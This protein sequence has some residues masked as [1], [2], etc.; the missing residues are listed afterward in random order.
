ML[1]FRRN[2]FSAAAKMLI[3]NDSSPLRLSGSSS[4]ISN[5][6]DRDVDL[7]DPE[8]ESTGPSFQF[9]TETLLADAKDI[10]FRPLPGQWHSMERPVLDI[11]HG[12]TSSSIR[13]AAEKLRT[14]CH[15]IVFPTETVYGIGADARLSNSVQL[16]FAVKNRP[17]DNPLIV[18]IASIAMLRSLLDSDN[19][20]NKAKPFNSSLAAN[21]PS[22]TTK[23][24]S[25][26]TAKSISKEQSREECFRGIPEIYWP[27]IEKFWPGPLTILL[28]L[29]PVTTKISRFVTAGQKTFGVRMPSNLVALA[30]LHIANAPLAA[31][32][33]NTSSKPSPTTAQ[34]VLDDLKDRIPVI[35]DGGPC[36]VGLESTVVDGLCDPP[37]I[38][39][40]GGI[41][42]EQIQ[43]CGNGWERCVVYQPNKLTEES[44][45]GLSEA[46]ESRRSMTQSHQT[47]REQKWVPRAPGMKYRHYSPEADVVVTDG[48][49]T[50]AELV[51][52]L[53]QDDSA[54]GT[55]FRSAKRIGVLISKLWSRER[56]QRALSEDK[57]IIHEIEL[58]R[59]D[60]D[61]SRHIFGALRAMDAL[62]PDEDDNAHEENRETK[63]NS[64]PSK[65]TECNTSQKYSERDASPHR[66]AVDIILVEGVADKD[67]GLAIMNRL[68]KAAVKYVD[69]SLLMQLK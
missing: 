60:E 25:E 65:P 55:S 10:K 45:S 46:E 42:L 13:K 47:Q 66:A 21:D 19:G 30:L 3:H 54:G 32:S 5:F 11:T 40:P 37:V 49:V 59:D 68:R 38:L 61:I 1:P 17:A 69:A 33:A 53:T 4:S 67:R 16:I 2:I 41:T 6:A 34:H 29:N 57:Q 43:S 64:S 28:P 24:S 9:T 36:Q 39:R 52:L 51:E 22:E 27:L 63:H 31:P 15:P 50:E 56:L 7:S 18:H 48:S 26:A 8:D 58:G 14:S 44:I 62:K 35:I 23:V 20:S 12:T